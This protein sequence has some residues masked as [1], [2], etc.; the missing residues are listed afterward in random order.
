MMRRDA[1]KAPLQP[2]RVAELV[3][4]VVEKRRPP[5][6]PIVGGMSRPIWLLGGLPTR[7][8]DAAMARVTRRMT[9]AGG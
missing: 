7:L 5:A 3:Q 9:R 8:Q 6:K 1:H 2:E 4:R